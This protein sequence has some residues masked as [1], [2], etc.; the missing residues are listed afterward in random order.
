[1]GQMKHATDATSLLT[2][3]GPQLAAIFLAI[4]CLGY[5]KSTHIPN[6]LLCILFTLNSAHHLR[7]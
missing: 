1:M 2:R 4:N 5:L 7:W 6:N 3:I